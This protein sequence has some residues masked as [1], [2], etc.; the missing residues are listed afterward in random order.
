MAEN[1]NFLTQAKL[2]LQLITSQGKYGSLVGLEGKKLSIKEMK[3]IAGGSF[4]PITME[5]IQPANQQKLQTNNI[6]HRIQKQIDEQ[7]SDKLD[8]LNLIA[9]NMKT[10]TPEATNFR[11]KS[12]F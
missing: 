7:K 2:N 6:L 3:E 9:R 11:N 5:N 1:L 12:N 8:D 10:K 4:L